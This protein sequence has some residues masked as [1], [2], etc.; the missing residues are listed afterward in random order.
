MFELKYFAKIAAYEQAEAADT[1]RQAP[2]PF[3]VDGLGTDNLLRRASRRFTRWIMLAVFAVMRQVWPVA[4]IGRLVIVTRHADVCTVLEDSGRFPVPFGPEMKVLTGGV[5]FALGLDGADHTFQRDIMNQAVVPADGAHIL[6]RT[7]FFTEALIAGSGGRIDVVR[8][9][10]GRVFTE[11]CSDYFGLDLDE[12]DAFL[13][14]SITLSSLLFADP[15]GN[16]NTRKLA[17]NGAV[18]IRYLI[19][20]AVERARQAP[21]SVPLTPVIDRLVAVQLPDGGRLDTLTI[22]SMVIGIM[23]GMVPTNSLAAGKIL[24]ELQRRD[25]LAL[26]VDAA[27]GAEHDHTTM[28][29]TLRDSGAFDRGASPDTVIADARRAAPSAQRAR[30]RDIL[31]EAA[32]LNPALMPGQFRHSPRDTSIAGT[33][34]PAGSVLLVATASAL[35]DS[36]V[37]PRPDTFEPGRK[38]DPP[39]MFGDGDHN[40]LGTYLALEQIVEIFQIL[41]SQPAI[42]FSKDPAGRLAY[43]GA[44]PRRLDMEFEPAIAPAAQNLINIT[45]AVEPWRFDTVRGLVEALGNPATPGSPISLALDKTGLVHFAS[46]SVFNAADPDD[47]AAAPLPR[48]VFELNVDGSESAA[49]DAVTREAGPLL[50][51]IFALVSGS[52]KADLRGRLEDLKTPLHLLPWGPIGINFNGTP[53]CP[54]GDIERQ[55]ELTTFARD[56]LDRYLLKGDGLQKRA[57]DALAYVRDLTKPTVETSTVD[58]PGE[59]ELRRRGQALRQFLVRPSRR[60]LGISAWTGVDYKAGW[61]GLWPALQSTGGLFLALMA[62]TTFV[63]QG[64]AIHHAIKSDSWVNTALAL[65]GVVGLAILL[66][67]AYVTNAFEKLVKLCNALGEAAIWVFTSVGFVLAFAAFLVFLAIRRI[68]LPAALVAAALVSFAAV[69]CWW[70]DL[71]LVA[72]LLLAAVGAAALCVAALAAPSLSRR[73]WQT[74]GAAVV[75]AAVTCGA[76]GCLA[77]GLSAGGRTVV[78]LLGAAFAAGLVRNASFRRIG[79]GLL[80]ALV[81]AVAAV[82][83]V[84]HWPAVWAAGGVGVGWL[85]AFSLAFAGGLMATVLCWLIPVLVFLGVLYWYESHD[86]PDDRTAPLD[87]I[88]RIAEQENAPGYAQNHITAVTAIKPGAFRKFTLALSLWAI[89]KEIQYWF[90]PGFVLNMGTIHYAKWFRLPGTEMMVFLSN[91]DG[92]WQSYLEDFITKAHAGQS[93]VWSHGKGFPKTRLLILGGAADGD[94]FKRW[95]RRQQVETQFW[96]ARFPQ[97]TTEQI[98]TNALIHDG[99]MRAQTDTAA[100]AWLDCFGTMPRPAN[101][102]EGDE[103]QSLVFRGL[104]SHPYTMSAAITFEDGEVPANWLKALPGKVTFGEQPDLAAGPPSFVA[105]SAQGIARCLDGNDRDAAA[106]TM[107]TFPPVFRLGM[108]SRARVLG[109]HGP[110]AP[111]GW[112]WADIDRQDD[113]GNT[114]RG[115]DALLFVYGTSEANCAA[116]LAEH[117]ALLGNAKVRPLLTQPTQKTLQGRDQDGDKEGGKA[118]YEHFGYRDGISQPVIRGSQREAHQDDDAQVVDPGE[119]IL[120]YVNSGGYRAPA[121]TLPAERDGNDDLETDTPDFSSRFPDFARSCDA[122]MRDFGRNGTFIAVRELAQDVDGFEAF[123]SAQEQKLNSY[124][125]L[126]Q[127]VGGTVTTDWV[128]AKMMG[129]WRNGASMIAAPHTIDGHMPAKPADNDF[130]FAADDPQ[131]LR[132]PFGSHIRR[133][134]PRGSLAPDDPTQ[135]KTERRHRLLR[136]G[137]TYQTETEKGLLFV[138]VCADLER[139]FEFLQQ[140][141]I[142]SPYFHGLSNEPDPFTTPPPGTDAKDYVFTIPT[143]AGSIKLEGLSSFVTVKAG[144]YFFMPSRSALRYLARNA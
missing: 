102:I 60:R 9:L 139:Q 130:N 127:A 43:L 13:D 49:L 83:V 63:I 140:T 11:T 99:L 91:Y 80:A 56:A 50:E 90:R 144:G 62:V 24:E 112:R 87:H 67:T 101:A 48:L 72:H 29:G 97:L 15:L 1:D 35:R 79:G 94:R 105:F 135:A 57:M 134:F 31:M 17:L 28:L 59:A 85:G 75:G 58:D 39:L 111:Q 69:R 76:V 44:F 98:R 18:R 128:A 126:A 54:V 66:G 40:C 27:R 82:E 108:A 10:L 109:D 121:I 47:A 64:F 4:R 65:A 120:G 32:R 100:R 104:A 131:G 96:Y 115:V 70:P 116:A 46:L 21:R 142:G 119:L 129:R 137:R 25:L 73:A 71:P 78:V 38:I 42:A 124:P 77:P 45:A 84:A 61:Q 26:A 52:D 123:L 95:V 88:A 36:R 53:D 51:P 30:L 19:D 89:G 55:R 5:I 74:V 33:P 34:V 3:D 107:V 132:C 37:F 23:T 125:G 81:V 6:G 114:E 122:D 136:R 143:P 106:K 12:P 118:L 93:A 14:R 141:W 8:D 20:R 92:S 117:V 133:A 86:V 110:S 138:G 68:V 2:P 16:A 103:I 113:Q 7:R 41:L 22:R